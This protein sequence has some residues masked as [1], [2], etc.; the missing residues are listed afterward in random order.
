MLLTAG[1]DGG[2][3][4]VARGEVGHHRRLHHAP[5]RRRLVRKQFVPSSPRLLDRP[6]SDAAPPIHAVF[7]YPAAEAPH[8]EIGYKAAA[9]FALGCCTFTGLWRWLEQRRA[10]PTQEEASSAGDAENP[11]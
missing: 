10:T 9:G 1:M 7:I 11:L 5:L 4:S 3:D 8:Y 6:W 2:L